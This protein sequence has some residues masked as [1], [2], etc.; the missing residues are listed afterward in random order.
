MTPR[1]STARRA[2]H[3]GVAADQGVDHEVLNR[4]RSRGVAAGVRVERLYVG[5][6]STLARLSTF[7]EKDFAALNADDVRA[8]VTLLDGFEVD[9]KQ[10]RF[11][12]SVAS[13][14]GRNDSTYGRVLEYSERRDVDGGW[15]SSVT[16]ATAYTSRLADADKARFRELQRLMLQGGT[17][18]VALNCEVALGKVPAGAKQTRAWAELQLARNDRYL[19][20]FDGVTIALDEEV[21]AQS[22]APSAQ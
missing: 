9:F 6:L 15:F 18:S 20:L 12:V 17:K 13:K 8:R 16:H 22:G 1:A 14:R 19:T 3:G 10:T 5:P 7:D 21:H 4:R 2:C 11:A